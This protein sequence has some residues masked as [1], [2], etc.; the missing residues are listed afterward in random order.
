MDFWRKFVVLEFAIN[1]PQLHHNI[2]WIITFAFLTV[3]SLAEV[4]KFRP[5]RCIRLLQEMNQ[6]LGSFTSESFKWAG[7]KMT[8]SG[9][10]VGAFQGNTDNDKTLTLWSITRRFSTAKIKTRYRWTWFWATS[11]HF[12]FS[13]P[14]HPTLQKILPPNFCLLSSSPRSQLHDQPIIYH[15]NISRWPKDIDTLWYLFLYYTHASACLVAEQLWSTFH[16]ALAY[17]LY[18]LLT[19]YRN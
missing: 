6:I 13:Q 11:L 9:W 14:I 12:R 10:P 8:Q 15:P 7:I 3:K 16:S 4:D 17:T 1:M 19:K 18:M 5:T 2:T